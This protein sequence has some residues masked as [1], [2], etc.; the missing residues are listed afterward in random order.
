MNSNK[1][2]KILEYKEDLSVNRTILLVADNKD[3]ISIFKFLFKDTGYELLFE[4][5]GSQ[6][7]KRIRQNDKI[8]LLILTLQLP[9]ISGLEVLQEANLINDKIKIVVID[10]FGVPEMKQRALDLGAD[11]FFYEPI[12]PQTVLKSI[13]EI[14]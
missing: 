4:S 2:E 8:K 1:S 10:N 13:N 14:L 6:G 9:D 7:L 3:T 11:L 5:T 12:N